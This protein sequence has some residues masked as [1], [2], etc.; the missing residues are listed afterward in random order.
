MAVKTKRNVVDDVRST[1]TLNVDTSNGGKLDINGKVAF[2][3]PREYDTQFKGIL[4]IP[5]K[6]N[7]F[8][9]DAGSQFND[10]KAKSYVKLSAD[11][12]AVV[13]FDV[14]VDRTPDPKGTFRVNI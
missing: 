7:T 14:D 3:S 10:R 4:K 5:G 9:A 2:N 11:N 12:A 13:D 1:Y 6:S 8:D